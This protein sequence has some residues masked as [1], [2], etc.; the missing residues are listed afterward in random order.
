MNQNE[1]D[2]DCGGACNLCPIEYP[3][4]GVFG[5]N[6]LHG[7]DTLNLA[8]GDYSLRAEMKEGSS[9][10]VVLTKVHGDV[11]FYVGG[12]NVGWSV[13]TLT[14]PPIEY[15]N[16]EMLNPGKADVNF[17]LPWGAGTIRVDYYENGAG[18]TKTKY[19]VWG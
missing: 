10:R 6:I 16:F 13:S 1:A 5:E 14:D 7:D 8:L 18:L 2:I 12:S 19:V 4:T 11:W 15:Q 17:H 9:L 3:A